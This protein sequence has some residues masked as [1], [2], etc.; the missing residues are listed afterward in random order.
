MNSTIQ[1]IVAK[2]QNHEARVKVL[3]EKCGKCDTPSLK[4]EDVKIVEESNKIL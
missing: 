2:V 3:E 4:D 1:Q